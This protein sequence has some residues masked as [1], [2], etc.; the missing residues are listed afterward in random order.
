MSEMMRAGRGS[1]SNGDVVR[2]R[3]ALLDRSTYRLQIH[4]KAGIPSLV[5][6]MEAQSR[7]KA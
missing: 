6:M 4:S 2:G 5:R 1:G 7:N 3:R